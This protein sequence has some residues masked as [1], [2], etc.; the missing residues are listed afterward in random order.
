VSIDITPVNTYQLIAMAAARDPQARALRFLPSGEIGTS[1]IILSQRELL[2]QITRTANMFQSLGVSRQDVVSI[3]LPNLPQTQFAFWGAQAAGIVNP[4]N[5]LLSPSH[6]A[7]IMRAAGTKIVVA[8]G[9]HPA[10][11]I[12]QKASAASR[13]VPSVRHVIQVGSAGSGDAVD[14]DRLIACHLDQPMPGIGDA[15]AGDTASYFHTGGTTGA[16]KLVRHTHWN[17]VAAASAT[18]A[19]C[20]FDADDVVML[21]LPMFHVAGSI[22]LSLASLSAGAELVLPTAAGNRDPLVLKNYWR[23]VEECGAT[24]FGGVPTSLSDIVESADHP[25]IPLKKRAIAL[26]GGAPL[27]IELQQRFTAL[28]GRPVHP[29]YG[30][31]ETSGV[32]AIASRDD[33]PRL[34]SVGKPVFGME[35]RIVPLAAGKPNEQP[36]RPG[37]RGIIHVKGECVSDGYGIPSPDSIPL[38]DAE[39]WL[40]TGDIGFL[41]SEGW[42]YITGREK[43]TIIRSGHNIDPAVIEE[44]AALHPDVVQAVAVGRPDRRAGEV[45]V[46]FAK[47]RSGSDA[48]AEQIL[49]FVKERISEAPAKPVMV[50]LVSDIPLTAVG[51]IYRPA[52]REQA[53]CEYVASQLSK[54]YNVRTLQVSMV[55]DASTGETK[56]KID[57]PE[58]ARTRNFKAS[59]EH[60]LADNGFHYTLV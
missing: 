34:G 46:L 35:V 12:W 22:L 24:V 32:I 17:E 11:D 42:L 29:I 6:I 39:G 52:I 28:T 2:G 55:N 49:D 5:F 48:S 36:Y 56:L 23:I 57:L 45:P 7:D 27:T 60:W 43:D 1:P 10:L 19:A 53:I 15:R 58:H 18:R 25:S 3:L 50:K 8:L 33:E 30:M 16:P 59:A 9:P 47:L 20:G 31:T 37:T 14:F 54:I 4:I 51:K 38:K 26:T 40:N 44:V 21:G 41:D 13:L